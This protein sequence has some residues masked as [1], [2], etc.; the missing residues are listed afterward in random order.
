MASTSSAM[1]ELSCSSSGPISSSFQRRRRWRRRSV[2][3]GSGQPVAGGLV[4]RRAPRARRVAGRASHDGAGEQLGVAQRVGE[5]VGADRVLP[6]AG[7]ADERPAG[8]QAR[9]R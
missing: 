9:R 8:P 6:V 4:A 2:N 3:S 7:V 5:P 1:A